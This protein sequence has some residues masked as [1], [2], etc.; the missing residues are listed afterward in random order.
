MFEDL[1]DDI[2]KNIFQMKDED[3]TIFMEKYNLQ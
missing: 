3:L 1:K 2:L